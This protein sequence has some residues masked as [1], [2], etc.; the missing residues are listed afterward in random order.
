MHDTLGCDYDMMIAVLHVPTG[1]RVD[2]RMAFLSRRHMLEL[3]D[4]WNGQQPGVWVYWSMT[5]R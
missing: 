4:V 1:Q 2:R 3:L 5:E